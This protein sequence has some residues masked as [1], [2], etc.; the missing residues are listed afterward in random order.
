MLPFQSYTALGDSISIDTYPLHDVQQ[1]HPGKASTDRLGAAALLFRND[2]KL[3][4]EFRGRD[5]HSLQPELRFDYGRDDLTADG[6]TTESLLG[7][8]EHV[9]RDHRPALVTITAGGND[10]LGHIGHLFNPVAA[11]AK[12]LHHAVARLLHL[13][14]H[15]T[16]LL[17]TVY[18]PSDGTNLLPD[19]DRKLDRE[20]EW[21]LAYNDE[22]RRF[23]ATDPRLR[24]ADIH[25]HFLGHGAAVTEDER[26]YLVESIIEP[27]ARGASE[28]RRVWLEALGR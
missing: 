7:Q 16:V 2:D 1:R 17:G 21:L 26:W 12:R 4:P 3:W 13:R 9:Q 25:R 27:S 11:I 15:A 14:P 8:I 18:D 28:V 5:L 6:A 24:L 20:A 10:L 19:F 23:A 22:V